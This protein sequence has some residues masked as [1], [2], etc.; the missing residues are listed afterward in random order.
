MGKVISLSE[1][2]RKRDGALLSV[3]GEVLVDVVAPLPIPEALFSIDAYERPGEKG[4][5]LR[6]TRG[7]EDFQPAAPH[8]T[9]AREHGVATALEQ[10]AV[11][12]R[13]SADMFEREEMGASLGSVR[14]F[15][16]GLRY[17]PSKLARMYHKAPAQMVKHLRALADKIEADGVPLE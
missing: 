4:L 5:D 16:D 10:F 13:D 1:A 15:M 8:L 3:N 2:R 17:T 12:L 9:A 7:G 6:L 14:L 11:E